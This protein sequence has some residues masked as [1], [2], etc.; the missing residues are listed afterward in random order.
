MRCVM[1][2]ES[3]V[4]AAAAASVTLAGY[5]AMVLSAVFVYVALFCMPLV[6]YAVCEDAAYVCCARSCVR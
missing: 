1:L 5:V 4:V 6:L 3:V 2:P